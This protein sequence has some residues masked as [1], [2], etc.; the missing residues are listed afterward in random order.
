LFS[1]IAQV[2]RLLSPFRLFAA[3]ST[4]AARERVD[5]ALIKKQGGWKNDATVWEYI[6]EGQQLTDNASL[7]LLEKLD[8]LMS[9]R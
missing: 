7:V 8:A 9:K 6:D 2:K 4:S 1:T 5:F 3:L